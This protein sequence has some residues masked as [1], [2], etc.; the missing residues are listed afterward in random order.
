MRMKYSA[1]MKTL[2]LLL[3]AGLLASCARSVDSNVYTDSVS[4]GK[5]IEGTIINVRAVTIKAHDKLQDNT[6]GGLAGGGTGALAGSR[7]GRGN[8]KL[9]AEVGG[10]VVGAVA[11]ALAQDVLS[12]SQGM[13]YMVKIDKQYIQEYFTISK[14]LSGN[15]KST[16]EQDMT[17]TQVNTRTDVVSIVQAADPALHKGSRVYV[18]YND[19]RP[20]LVAQE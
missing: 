10:A 5:V 9:A 19:D 7:T 16:V 15:G 1:V 14:K 8:G 4:A 12:T 18:I 6:M 17:S 20:R 13:E 11:G 3:C 2:S